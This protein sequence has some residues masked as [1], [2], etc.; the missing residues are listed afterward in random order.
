V[1]LSL[2][3]GTP[4]ARAAAPLAAPVR[5]RGRGGVGEE[6]STRS[7]HRGHVEGEEIRQELNAGLLSREIWRKRDGERGKRPRK[8]EGEATV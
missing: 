6:A 2:C 8:E 3:Q 4:E 7:R 5:Q 1:S